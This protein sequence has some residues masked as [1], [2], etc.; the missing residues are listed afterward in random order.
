ML[1]EFRNRLRQHA[2]RDTEHAREQAAEGQPAAM[3]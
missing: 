3:A 2:A 1:S